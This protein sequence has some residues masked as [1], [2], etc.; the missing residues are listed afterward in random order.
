MASWAKISSSKFSICQPSWMPSP[1]P[2][3]GGLRVTGKPWAALPTNT[4]ISW[5]CP[6]YRMTWKKWSL[7][8]P[9]ST[10]SRRT[11]KTWRRCCS[12]KP[13][14]TLRFVA[15]TTSATTK[16]NRSPKT[17]RRP[18]PS[19]KL[20]SK[21]PKTWSSSPRTFL[22]M[23]WGKKTSI[24]AA[25]QN[26]TPTKIATASRG[27]RSF[28]RSTSNTIRSSSSKGSSRW[29]SAIRCLLAAFRRWDICVKWT[30]SRVF[31]KMTPAPQICCP[32]VCR[33]SHSL[34]KESNRN[35]SWPKCRAP[36]TS[37]RNRPWTFWPASKLEAKTQTSAA[38]RFP[39]NNSAPH[40]LQKPHSTY[41]CPTSQPFR[42]WAPISSWCRAFSNL[43]T[44]RKMTNLNTFP[45]TTARAWSRPQ[46]FKITSTLNKI[47]HKNHKA[48]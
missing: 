30:T 35:A 8:L 27:G 19:S 15:L 24:L 6:F 47:M 13:P 21:S 45:A 4:A 17:S 36:T 25:Q 29:L 26:R 33:S 37:W 22:A 39:Q 34:A 46:S 20:L 16:L 48:T 42:N 7:R 11:R 3:I 5:I 23:S 2:T 43:H 41:A 44:W 38:R 10:R 31:Q 12:A 18:W 14:S 32:N 40:V 9:A 1:Q 28:E